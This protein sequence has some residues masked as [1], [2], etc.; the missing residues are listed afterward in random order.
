MKF[1]DK[2][3]TELSDKIRAERYSEVSVVEE[4]EE[5]DVRSLIVDALYSQISISEKLEFSMTRLLLTICNISESIELIWAISIF[6]K[7]AFEVVSLIKSG[8]DILLVLTAK[9]CWSISLI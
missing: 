5:E 4:E 7:Y 6:A 1:V 3:S 9:Y 8:Y 2:I